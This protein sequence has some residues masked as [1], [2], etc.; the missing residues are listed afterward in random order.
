[1]DTRKYLHAIL[2]VDVVAIPGISEISALEI[3]SGD[4]D[5]PVQ[6]AFPKPFRILAEPLPEQQDF[7][8]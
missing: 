2:G 1:M 3:L 8:R 6:M 5:R 4:R 7:R